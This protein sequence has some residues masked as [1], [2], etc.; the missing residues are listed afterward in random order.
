MLPLPPPPAWGANRYDNGL[1]KLAQTEQ[2]V[3]QMQRDLEVLQPRLVEA[4]VATDALLAQIAR[5]TEV[6]NANKA[7]VQA[8][9]VICTAQ[10][11]VRSLLLVCAQQ[12]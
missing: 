2:Q 7:A 8:E 3:E 11:Q 9:E 5:D 10:A 12:A 6:A 1:L 4:T